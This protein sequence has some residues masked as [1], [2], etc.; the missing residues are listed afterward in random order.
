M[1]LKR[2]RSSSGL[3]PFSSSSNN[4]YPSRDASF[5]PTPSHKLGSSFGDE[6]IAMDG[7]GHELHQ[8]DDWSMTIDPLFDITPPHLPS[9]TRKRFRNNRPADSSIHENTYQKLYH[10]QRFPPSMPVA[11]IPRTPS[12]SSNSSRKP[13]ISQASLHNFW[14]FPHR[15]STSR[16]ASTDNHPSHHQNIEKITCQDCDACLD[17]VVGEYAMDVEMGG[18]GISV[19]ESEYACRDC[20]RRVC[21]M[22]AVVTPGEGRECLQCKISRRKWVGGIGWIQSTLV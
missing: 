16:H 13:S 19:E 5:S 18:I 6:D 20:A 17:M 14:T 22:C 1:S 15:S 7:S 12:D 4:S 11:A 9:R 2:K 21:D 10:A 8:V 3:S